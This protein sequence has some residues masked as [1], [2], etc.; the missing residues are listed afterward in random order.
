MNDQENK[1]NLGEVVFDDNN[2]EKKSWACSGQT[3]S[4][5]L[6]VFLSQIFVILLIIFGCFGEIIFQKHVKNPL[7]GWKFCV[8]QQDTFYTHQDYAQVNFYKKS[9]LCTI[10]RSLR[11]GKV[12]TFLQLALL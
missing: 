2:Q 5:Y 11:D 4:R 3:C 6:I 12:T 1:I 9:R 10:G 7:F 8:V